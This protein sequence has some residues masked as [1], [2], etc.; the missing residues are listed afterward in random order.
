MKRFGRILFWILTVLIMLGTLA[1]DGE[2]VLGN[3]LEAATRGDPTPERTA[4]IPTTPEP[5]HE[6]AI[7]PDETPGPP[8]MPPV[9]TPTP[10]IQ[11]TFTPTE[12]PAIASTPTPVP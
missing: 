9:P 4:Y 6:E 10:E 12:L 3:A 11:W 8:T 1:C 7:L 5:V 2:D